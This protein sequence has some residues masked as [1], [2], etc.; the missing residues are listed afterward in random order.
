MRGDDEGDF[1]SRLL[2]TLEDDCDV[3]RL[4]MIL[5]SGEDLGGHIR[6]IHE[7]VSVSK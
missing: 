5:I 4:P 6:I 3:G 7:G 1:S 2:N